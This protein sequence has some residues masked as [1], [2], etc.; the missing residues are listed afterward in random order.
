MPMNIMVQLP[1][2]SAEPQGSDTAFIRQSI[3]LL[4]YWL[5]A[6]IEYVYTEFD[7][8]PFLPLQMQPYPIAFSILDLRPQ[9]SLLLSFS[10]F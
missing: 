10:A 7:R 4:T 9:C 2:F 6:T 3:S 5:L 8:A 1:G